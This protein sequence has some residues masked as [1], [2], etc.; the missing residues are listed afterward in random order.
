[1][2]EKRR[3]MIQRTFHVRACWDADAGVYYAESDIEGLH[4]EA[5]TLQ[6]FEEV[7]H[8]VAAELIVANHM[9]SADL[10]KTPL[11]DLVPAIVWQRP[12]DEPAAA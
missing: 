1:M 5:A 11:Q 3:E 2:N 9:T 6:E 10:A 12:E 7:L 8:D 4:I